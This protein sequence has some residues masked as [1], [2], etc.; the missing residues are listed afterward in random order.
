MGEWF[1]RMTDANALYRAFLS[2]KKASGWK[3]SVKAFEADLLLNLRQIQ[4]DLREGT[5]QP[6]AYTEFTLHERGKTRRIK[7]L[8]IRDRVVQKAM[9]DEVLMPAIRPHLIY[10]N[11]ASLKGKGI[12]FTRGRLQCQL[13]KYFRKYG[14]CGWGYKRDFS[15]YF[16]NIDHDITIDYFGRYIDDPLFMR[17]FAQS[18]EAYRIDISALS[19]SEREALKTR[20]INLLTH[21]ASTEG[22]FFLN[23][24]A[25]IGSP[26]SQIIGIALPTPMDNLALNHPGVFSYNRYMDDSIALSPS[27][28]ALEELREKDREMA[29][30][31]GIFI[32]EKKTCIFPLTRGFTF[33]QIKYSFTETGKI[34]KRLSPSAFTRERRKLK[35][36][37]GGIVGTTMSYRD[38]ANAYQSWRG[39][40]TKY[41][42]HRSVRRMDAL[43]N[44]LFI[45][46]FA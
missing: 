12:S 45:D 15:K 43:F 41:S 33:L 21:P 39:N 22:R 2:A 26:L 30:R 17:L 23:R 10:D 27:K 29:K 46:N 6:S 1:D 8:K 36:Y 7:S 19:E 25:G 3:F 20:P 4:K 13:E 9:C 24:S 28:D 38:V 31:L 32:N 18:L 5:Y 40:A 42:S 16:D 34:I 37:A 14:V 44:H 11:G 35:K